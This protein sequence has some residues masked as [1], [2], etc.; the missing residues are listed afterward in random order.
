MNADYL[1]CEICDEMW[2]YSRVCD[3]CTYNIVTKELSPFEKFVAGVGDLFEIGDID[4]AWAK[5]IK[6]NNKKNYLYLTLS[7][8]KYLRNLDRTDE[9]L[10]NLNLFCEKWFN[11]DKIYYEK[12]AW[13]IESGSNGD[14]LHVHCVC[15][16]KT[17]HKH[18]RKLKAYWAKWF[19][20]N[21][22]MTSISLNGKTKGRGEYC[23]FT[24]DKQEILE[25]K[26]EYF[27]NESKGTH[28]NL[29]DEGLRGLRGFLY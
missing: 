11:Q 25:D 16:M 10:K 13:V 29:I 18:A 20:N 22:L 14:H 8:D 7:P 3:D 6:K 28:S 21:Q 19:P 9:N 17:S 1:R 24:F 12:F 26:L 27:K 5:K 15:E 23:W 2:T 4:E